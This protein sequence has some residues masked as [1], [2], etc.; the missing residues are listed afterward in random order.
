MYRRRSLFVVLLMAVLALGSLSAHAQVHTLRFANFFPGPAGQSQLVDELVEDLKRL[1]DGR[2][3]VEHYPGGTLLGAPE[4]YDGVATGIAHIGMSN[5]G[6]TFGRFMETELLDLPLGFPNAWVANKVVQEF[7]E[8]YQ[9][10]EWDDTV[11]LTLHSSPVN[12]ILTANKPVTQL[13]D[14]RGLALRGTGYIARF[15]EALGATARPIATPEAY[16][17]VARRVIDGLMIPYETVVTFRFGEVTDYITEAWPLGQVYTFYI[18]MNKAEW[19]RLGPEL[20]GIITDYFDNEFRDKLTTMWNDIDIV[21]YEYAVE[22]GYEFHELQG[23]E[24]NRWRDVANRVINDYVEAMVARGHSREEMFERIAFVRERIE[25]WT[26]QQIAL[27]IKSPTGPPE[28][29]V[30]F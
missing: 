28:V 6:Y 8:K 21:G 7:Y 15:V 25:Y 2:I 14:M 23:E 18:V 13:A 24:L 9:P 19:N 17:S 27:G 11:V 12:V 10:A 16:D 4:I 29:L 3:V 26:E 20:Q 30:D 22:S 5:L 1:S